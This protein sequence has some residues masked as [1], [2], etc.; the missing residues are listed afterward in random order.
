MQYHVLGV[1]SHC[2]GNVVVPSLWSGIHPPV[3]ACQ[4]CRAT[5][6]PPALRVVP[7][8]PPAPRPP[9]LQRNPW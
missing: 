5:A 1:C 9:H 7:M 8:N 2:G 4:S 6:A 3:P